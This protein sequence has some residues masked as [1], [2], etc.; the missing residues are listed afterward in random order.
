MNRDLSLTLYTEIH[1]KWTTDLKHKTIKYLGKKSGENL[2]NLGLNRVLKLDTKKALKRKINKLS[3]I[4]LKPFL[5]VKDS[6][7][8]MKRQATEWENIFANHIRDKRIASKIH[9]EL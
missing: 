2:Q 4:K 3:F 9:K 7:K 8:K 6:I 1:S 5:S